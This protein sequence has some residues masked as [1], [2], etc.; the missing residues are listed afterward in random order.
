MSETP[1]RKPTIAPAEGPCLQRRA[2]L[3]GC[4]GAA[5]L[6]GAPAAVARLAAKDVRSLTFVN[7]HTAERLHATYWERGRY[8]DDALAEIN[9]VLRDHRSNEVRAID[10]Q[11]L[12][13]L[14]QVQGRLRVTKPFHV[15][16]GYRS[17]ATNARLRKAS[18]GVAKRSLHMEGKAIDVRLP[19]VVL[20]DLRKAAL[21]LRAGGV[22]Y[23]PRPEFV[24]L[25]TGRV[26]HW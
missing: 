8:L 21:D 16:S 20:K 9:H 14:H 23:Y 5:S 10:P 6:L 13:L 18:S 2:F 17:P 12:D 24:H 19:G 1:D 26:R 25:D 7:T 3:R 22:G 15:I 11:L 4:A